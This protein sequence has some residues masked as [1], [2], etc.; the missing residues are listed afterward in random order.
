MQYTHGQA[1]KH[2]THYHSQ[3]DKVVPIKK[4]LN[5]ITWLN[6]E[7]LSVIVLGL[8]AHRQERVRQ[9]RRTNLENLNLTKADL[10]AVR[11]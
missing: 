7:D 8:H 3:I 6:L 2:S 4:L 5:S 10:D 9:L 1:I 11:V